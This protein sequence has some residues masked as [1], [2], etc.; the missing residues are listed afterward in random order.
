[1][2]AGGCSWAALAPTRAL[3]HFQ[4]AAFAY[5]LQ[6]WCLDLCLYFFFFLWPHLQ[7]MNS[8]ARGQIGAAAK[9]YVTATTPD[10]SHISDIPHSLQPC[11]IFNP[12][13]EA[14]DGTHILTETML[15]L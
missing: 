4:S 11:W 8:W 13:S 10:L 3:S 2:G 5:A 7:H 12:L 9:A 14:R 15:G 1:M 6:E